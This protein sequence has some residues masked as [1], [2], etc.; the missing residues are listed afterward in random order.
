MVVKSEEDIL[1][2]K[3]VMS[4]VDLDDLE[5]S[6]VGDIYAIEDIIFKV[7]TVKPFKPSSNKFAVE[8]STESGYT[9]SFFPVL[10]HDPPWSDLSK[11]VPYQGERKKKRKVRNAERDTEIYNKSKNNISSKELAE[12]YEL[13]YQAIRY[14]IRK[15]EKNIG[16]PS[17]VV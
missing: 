13:T 6:Q 16:T 17:N 7:V 2:L 1:T 11:Y 15:M 14:I 8:L 10:I 9:F 12:E 3:E 4:R 5:D